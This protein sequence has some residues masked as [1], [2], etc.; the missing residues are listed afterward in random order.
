MERRVGTCARGFGFG[1]RVKFRV[2][3]ETTCYFP[4]SVGLSI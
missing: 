3:V 1:V 2:R 4:L